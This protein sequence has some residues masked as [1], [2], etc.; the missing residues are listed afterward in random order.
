M[1]Y[2]GVIHRTDPWNEMDRLR[3]EV[4]HVFES[5]PGFSSRTYPYI[6]VW[7]NQEKMIV[8][9]ELPGYKRE[10]ISISIK[11]NELT[12]AGEREIPELKE[13][14]YCHRQERIHGNFERT[15]QLPFV[16]NEKKVTANFKNGV[17]KITLPRAEEDKP[18]KI[19]IL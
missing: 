16:V 18:K 3:S 8:S 19:E 17:L 13:N 12:I 4:N 9:T 15:I 7:T 11:G 5:Y 10:N 1:F 6:N 14:D 2:R